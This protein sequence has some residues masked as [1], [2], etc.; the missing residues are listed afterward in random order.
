MTAIEAPEQA[1]ILVGGLGS[2]L[3]ALTKDTPKP[4]LQAGSRPF[5]DYMIEACARFGFRNIVLLAG[6]RGE[7]MVSYVEGTRRWLS[8]DVVLTLVVEPEPRGTAGALKFA[9]DHLAE[10]FL[11]LNGDS[12]FDTNWLD[13][14]Q[15][16]ALSDPMVVMMLR[17][18]TDTSRYGIVK[19][20][21]DRVV[22]FAERGNGGEGLINGGVYLVRRDILSYLPAS[23]SLEREVL[24]AMCAKG[25]VRGRVHGGFLLDI[26]VPESLA[27]A[28]TEL[29]RRRYRPA[30]FFDRDGTL[31]ADAG[32]T[33]RVADLVFL[34]GAAAAVKRVNDLGYYAFLVT[35]QAGIARGYF[36]EAD[37]DA[38]NAHLQ[39]RLRA[40]GAHLDDIRLAP[41]HPDGIM[42]PSGRPSD[43]RKPGG[44]MVMDLMRTWPVVKEAS[45]LVGNNPSDVGAAT[46]AGIKGLLYGGGNLDTFLAPYLAE[47]DYRGIWEGTR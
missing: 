30:V 45:L 37:A 17:R 10:R 46:A 31:N 44:G 23:G 36:T 25:L 43:W 15:S 18:V 41:D 28:Q 39:R 20:D 47:L 24:P 34:E 33:H 26:G 42:P 6:Y 38:F 32:Y 13:L 29:P 7:K 16:V 19:I 9:A 27:L 2:R 11:L 40:V 4:L 12:F 1:V 22:A 3:G 5:L 21:G 8:D 35:N 14:M